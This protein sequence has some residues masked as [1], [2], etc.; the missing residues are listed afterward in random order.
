MTKQKHTISYRQ[1]LHFIWQSIR[2]QKWI[3]FAIFLLDALAW[4]L[5]CLAFPY[6][7]SLIITVFNRFETNRLAAWQAL[8]APIVGG[9]CLMLFIELASRSMGFLLSKAMPKLQADIRMKMFDHI[10]RHTPRY[11]NERFAGAL[12][13]KITDMTTQVEQIIQQLFWPIL[14]A[15]VTCIAGSF[16]LWFIHNLI[17]VDKYLEFIFSRLTG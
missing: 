6:I 10:Q 3:F 5:D 17:I 13:N 11:F 15:L 12:A 9:I 14:P 16:V 1:L 7:L 2:M 8:Q 4:P